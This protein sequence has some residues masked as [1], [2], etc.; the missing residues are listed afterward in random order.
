[1]REV[2]NDERERREQEEAAFWQQ[3]NEERIQR[4]AALAGEKLG[5]GPHDQESLVSVLREESSRRSEILRALRE[6]PF[7]AAQR[8]TL[9]SQFESLRTWKENELVARFGSELAQG[10]FQLEQELGGRSRPWL[11]ERDNELRRP[12]ELLELEWRRNPRSGTGQ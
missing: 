11:A 6:S 4:I 12:R 1:V 5:L 3:R 9:Q 10:L 7:D 2:L 8:D